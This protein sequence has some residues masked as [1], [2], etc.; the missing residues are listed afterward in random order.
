[1]SFLELH[2]P[3]SVKNLLRAPKFNCLNCFMVAFM[4]LMW[5]DARVYC[6]YLKDKF[7]QPPKV[8]LITSNWTSIIVSSSKINWSVLNIEDKGK[9][10]LLPF[11]HRAPG[12]GRDTTRHL[13]EVYV[14][15]SVLIKGCK[16]SSTH[17]QRYRR[18][19]QG[20]ESVQV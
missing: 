6:K 11:C 9:L 2:Q 5:P 3:T 8:I 14:V 10:T 1:M 12:G 16:D 18:T 19:Y 15:V 13:L 7:S 20:S 4:V 17:G